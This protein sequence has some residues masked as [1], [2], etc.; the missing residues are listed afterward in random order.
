LHKLV[1]PGT[2]LE[3]SRFI[4]GTSSLFQSGTTRARR[5]LLDAAVHH[6]F[7]HFDTAP[8]YGFGIAERDLAPVLKANPTVKVTTKVGIYPPGDGDGAAASVLLR[9]MGGKLFP[10]LA[11][12]HKSFELRRAKLSLEQSLR[13][14]GRERID[15]YMLHEPQAHQVNCPEWLE[16]L[17]SLR[18]CGQVGYFGLATTCDRLRPFLDARSALVEIAQVADSL[19]RREADL[20]SACQRPLQITYGYVSR[21]RAAGD[22]SD[23]S[24]LLRRATARNACGPIIVSTKRVERIGQYARVTETPG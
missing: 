5:R 15:L 12:P 24:L 22:R 6:G 2:T 13:R 16:W 18:A 10:S 1:I 23:V 20:L 3:T 7:E 14:L 17:E 19:E 4:F 9:K 21:A 11:R 8:Y